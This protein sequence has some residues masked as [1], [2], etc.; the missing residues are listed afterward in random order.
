MRIFCLGGLAGLRASARWEATYQLTSPPGWG[1]AIPF[2]WP[3]C[4]AVLPCVW[5]WE[6]VAESLS[7]ESI[8]T[9]ETILAA[10]RPRSYGHGNLIHGGDHLPHIG[11]G[12]QTESSNCVLCS[13]PLIMRPI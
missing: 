12:G 13:A 7:L 2:V 11:C 4:P 10:L 9:P 6:I 3:G 8:F 5:R 1:E